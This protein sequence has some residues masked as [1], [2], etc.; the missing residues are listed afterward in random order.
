M[1]YCII[2]VFLL[3]GM[4]LVLA[5]GISIGEA[6]ITI[7][8]NV[9]EIDDD[10]NIT[11]IIEAIN[12]EYGTNKE[13]KTFVIN[14]IDPVLFE[15]TF[16]FTFLFIRNESVSLDT[17]EQYIA[18][19]NEKSKC[20]EE[21]ASFNTAWTKCVLDLSEYEGENATTYKE[22]FDECSLNLKEKGL[23][24]GAKDEKILNLEDEKEDTKNSKYIWGFVGL[25]LGAGALYL[26][27][28]RGGTPKEK[29]MGEFQKS[30]AR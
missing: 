22:D 14:N 7:R 16:P 15:E 9:T 13:S 17:V 30:Q 26:Y 12:N 10:G 4:P 19:L 3:L 1:K 6:T 23:D 29:S 24:L 28:R 18:C 2:L 20:A 27:E 5:N 8:A 25:L 11:I 21:K